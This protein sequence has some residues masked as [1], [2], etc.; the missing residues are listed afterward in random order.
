MK[1]NPA[2]LSI[3]ASYS[4]LSGPELLSQVVSQYKVK[5]AVKPVSE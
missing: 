4:T 1:S 5:D 3:T 2:R